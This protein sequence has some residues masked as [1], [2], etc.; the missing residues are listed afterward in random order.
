MNQPRHHAASV[1][2][3]AAAGTGTGIALMVPCRMVA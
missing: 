2:V 1:G 3:C